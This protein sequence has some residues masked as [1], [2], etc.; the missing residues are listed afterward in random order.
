MM[1]HQ[2]PPQKTVDFIQ[3]PPG[4]AAPTALQPSLQA[5]R[6]SMGTASGSATVPAS[7]RA[8]SPAGSRAPGCPKNGLSDPL[9]E[10]KPG[11]TTEDC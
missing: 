2:A 5:A 9:Y 7:E 10:A 1:E 3:P 8:G 11:S 4:R 6:T